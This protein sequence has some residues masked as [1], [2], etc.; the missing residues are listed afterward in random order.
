[1]N[2]TIFGTG[3][4][5]LVTGACLAK[6]G[7]TVICV[8]IDDTKL[9]KIT[10]GDIPFF[11]PG[12]SEL[13]KQTQAKEKLFFT[14]EAKSAILKAE[15]IFNCVGTPQHSD[16]RANLSYVN[17]VAK[18]VAIHAKGI[19]ILVNKSTVPPG[20]A[21]FCQDL[22][23][24]TNPNSEVEVVSNPEFLKEGAAIHDFTHPDKIVI[25][26]RTSKNS[27]LAKQLLRKVYLGRTRMYI[28]F[29]ETTWQTAEI[30]KYAN[31]A[32]LATK[33]SFI[34]EL[35]NICDT[36]GADVKVTAQAMGMDYRI[37]PKF[38]NAGI[39][40]G[41]SCFPKDVRALVNKARQ[42]GYEAKLLD[43]VDKTNQAQKLQIV[44][45][46]VS[47][48]SSD[49]AGKTFTILGLSFKPKTSDMR[50]APSLTVI[51][52]LI[53]MGAKIQAYDP[54]AKNEAIKSIPE[55][56]HQHIVFCD[57]LTQAIENSDAILLLTEWD[58][59]RSLNFSK[60]KDNVKQRIIFDGRNIY[61]P[62]IF[63]EEGFSY[64]GMGRK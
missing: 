22:I 46:V 37:S 52:E 57:N 36:V 48:F 19:K 27:E 54:I 61:Q 47:V 25:G 4:V 15:V 58:E 35:A 31:N 8:D 56:L 50:E 24:E 49:L 26:T 1:M 40:Y 39:G 20:T 30:I 6:L 23:Q 53:K 38:L 17:Q 32:F 18:T 14:T 10:N 59:F 44:N 64:F 33:I 42:F 2:I 7:H 16:G 28:P 3:Y 9:T 11:E 60:I 21:K 5:G 12:L 43:Q 29:L 13:V 41:G 45:K 62:E 34:N 51:P 55:K 63:S